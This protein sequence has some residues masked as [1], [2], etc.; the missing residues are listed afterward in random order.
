MLKFSKG[1]E[2]RVIPHAEIRPNDLIGK[3][4]KVVDDGFPEVTTLGGVLVLY[5]VEFENYGIINN[6]HEDY[7]EHA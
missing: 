1:D 2:V 3:V 7:L 6:V 4:G 5:A